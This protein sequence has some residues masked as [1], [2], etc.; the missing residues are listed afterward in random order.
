[1]QDKVHVNHSSTYSLAAKQD[2][3]IPCQVMSHNAMRVGDS[4]V[5]GLDTICPQNS[6]SDPYHL[7]EL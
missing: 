1:M 2:S 6:S 4:D 5:I 3:P 7:G